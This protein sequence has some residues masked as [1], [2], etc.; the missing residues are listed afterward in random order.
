MT[1]DVVIVGCGGQGREALSIIR[2]INGAATDGPV[3]RMLGFLADWLPD[4]TRELINRLGVSHLGPIE[5]LADHAPELHVVVAVGHPRDRRAVWRRIEPYG[6]RP[7]SLVHPAADLD[8]GTT[9]GD[10]LLV[11]AGAT[12]SANVVL[13]RHVHLN[14][15]STVGPDRVLGDFV[16]VGPQAAVSGEGLVDEGVLIG[17]RAAVLPGRRVGPDA[18]AGARATVVRDV[19]SGMVVKGVPAV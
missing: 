6:V 3:W 18:T 10:G 17:T 13:G 19:H 4:G 7:A 16:S 1:R 11:F 15:N 14:Q 9:A 5:A 2:A 8:P 12:V